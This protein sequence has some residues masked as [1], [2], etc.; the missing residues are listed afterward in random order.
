MKFIFFQNILQGMLIYYFAVYVYPYSIFGYD[1]QWAE[2]IGW[3]ISV[4]PIMFCI[5]LGAVH[6]V[7]KGEGNFKQVWLLY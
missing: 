1:E 6:A 2:K 7:Y 3:V 5:I 4:L